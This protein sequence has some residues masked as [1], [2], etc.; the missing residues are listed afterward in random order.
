MSRQ[1]H[2]GKQPKVVAVLTSLNSLERFARLKTRPCHLAE[3]R[4][5]H[6][7]PDSNWLPLGRSIQES[8]TP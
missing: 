1:A 4:L 5:D 7:G 6:I 3:I 8:G 2:I